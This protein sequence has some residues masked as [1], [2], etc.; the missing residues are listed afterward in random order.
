MYI[1]ADDANTMDLSKVKVATNGEAKVFNALDV[2]PITISSTDDSGCT[3]TSD[4]KCKG[5]KIDSGTLQTGD[6]GKVTKSV[7][8]WIDE[9]L[10]TDEIES[11]TLSLK[12]YIVSEVAEQS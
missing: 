4:G 3:S 7:K 12:L 5:Y 2:S 6:T 10:V 11:K 8:V 1:Y 9:S